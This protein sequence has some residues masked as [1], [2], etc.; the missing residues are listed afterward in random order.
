MEIPVTCQSAAAVGTR[1]AGAP[2]A[3]PLKGLGGSGSRGRSGGAFRWPSVCVFTWEGGELALDFHPL[4][5]GGKQTA[6]PGAG[7][8]QGWPWKVAWTEMEEEPKT[9]RCSYR[10]GPTLGARPPSPSEAQRTTVSQCVGCCLGWGCQISASIPGARCLSG[11]YTCVPVC[12]HVCVCVCC[13]GSC[14]LGDQLG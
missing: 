10:A 12:V 9:P 4:F 8:R 1:Q 13:P 5:S 6:L 2:A 3:G 14:F 7:E 11:V